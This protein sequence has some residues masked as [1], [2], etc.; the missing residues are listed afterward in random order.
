MRGEKLT[1]YVACVEDKVKMVFVNR[2][3]NDR[4]K[5]GKKGDADGEVDDMVK[6]GLSAAQS[7]IAPLSEHTALYED[8]ANSEDSSGGRYK[9]ESTPTYPQPRQTENMHTVYQSVP[10]ET[11]SNP[12]APGI[13]GSGADHSSVFALQTASISPTQPRKRSVDAAQL[14]EQVD[15]PANRGRRLAES[16]IQE[17]QD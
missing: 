1:V 9:T 13:S 12:R 3:G 16:R 14:D 5:K 17:S 8:E 11:V 2:K 4:R 10:V 15:E 7:N 6:V